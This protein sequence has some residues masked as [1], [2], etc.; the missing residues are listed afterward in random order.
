ML[1]NCRATQD[2]QQTYGESLTTA[3]Y[4][5]QESAPII[6]IFREKSVFSRTEIES[7]TWKNPRT[8]SFTIHICLGSASKCLPCFGP[9]QDSVKS[10]A[11]EVSPIGQS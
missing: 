4:V 7:D 1:H 9:N 2:M 10:K 5:N 8:I 11:S 3:I 6:F